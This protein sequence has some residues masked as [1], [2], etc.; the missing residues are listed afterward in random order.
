MPN[1]P[2]HSGTS[3]TGVIR[4]SSPSEALQGASGHDDTA[5][6]SHSE[7]GRRPAVLRLGV[8][9]KFVATVGVLVVAV[10][11]VALTG[12]VGVTRIHRQA[13]VLTEGRLRT[14]QDCADLISAA[15]QLHETALLQIAADTPQ[16]DASVGD[17]LDQTLVPGF[18]DAVSA[19]S[20]D[21]ADQPASLAEV[22]RIRAGLDPYLDLRRTALSTAARD[23][24]GRLDA[25][26]RTAVTQRIDAIFTDL[27][28]AGEQL[29]AHEAIRAGKTEQEAD[30]TYR[31]TLAA[32]S[33]G[34]LVSLLLALA[35]V[36][37]LV[38]NLVPRIRAYSQ[39]AS[40]VAAGRAVSSL[41]PGGRDELTVLGTA[42]N[43]MVARRERL[44]TVEAAQAEFVDT[45]Q[46]TGTEDEAQDLV[47][48]HLERS[49]PDSTVVVLRRNNSA[50]RLEA[51]TAIPAGDDLAERLVGA[52]PRSCTALRVG[53]T[54]H[55]GAGRRPL[56]TCSVCTD[57]DR[58][59]TCEPL[60]VAGEVI[61]SVLVTHPTR[62]D[63]DH[64]NLIRGT[65][66]QAAP[67]LANLRNLALAEFRANN[68]T[69]TG[70]PNKRATDD[71]LKRMVAQANRSVASL[72][73]IMLD[74]DHFKQINDRYGHGK[75]DE[76]LAAVGAVINTCLRASDFAGR[77]GGEEFLI[78]LPDTATST[79]TQVAERIRAAIAAITIPGVERQITASLG[80][81]DLLE[82]AGTADGLIHE[83]DR[84]L[85]TAKNHGR[86]RISTVNATHGASAT[87]PS[88]GAESPA[89]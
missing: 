64:E 36:T 23:G 40:E 57:R 28:G 48:R 68:D 59:S 51:A 60:L 21:F 16:T 65:V 37:G 47:Q 88:P 3:H 25:A 15:Y 45:L 66:A 89:G 32:L 72:T 6:V 61:G 75:G 62:P 22:A 39:F 70:L 13:A 11:A 38:R 29:R 56:L 79:A 55:E 34:V 50:N 20:R 42:L 83:A 24:S 8:R 31:S 54:H 19:L 81:A 85:Y 7:A 30:D 80:I 2:N 43:E 74:L 35:A 73:A 9:G 49:L 71:T 17:E 67:M 82:H 86:N 52:E 5:P 12:L 44:A 33:V 26:T 41:T 18:N 69:L 4:S 78:L 53:K 84:A 27:V 77:F 10:V 58:P 87:E 63:P 46:V 14:V 1:T 76:V